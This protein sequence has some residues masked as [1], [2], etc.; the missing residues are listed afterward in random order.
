MYNKPLSYSGMSLFKRCP[1]A[2]ED[3]YI[4]G[5]RSP[6]G[7]AAERGTQIH[8]AIEK[9]F[10]GAPYPS[11]IKELKPWQAYME[12]LLQYEPIAEAKVAVDENWEAVSYDDPKAILRGKIDLVYSVGGLTHILD[13]KT[14]KVYDTHPE[15]GRTYVALSNEDSK[16]MASFV[17]IDQPLVVHSTTYAI[18]EREGMINLLKQQI[19]DIRGADE[20]PPTPSR[21]NCKWCDLSW[22]NGGKCKAAP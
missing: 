18:P 20:F 3:V 10:L 22:R 13:W 17:Y 6:S 2:W 7:K 15:Q 14:G 12:H 4:N 16:Y 1:R 8:D 21:D 5:N 9:F 19:E 11:A